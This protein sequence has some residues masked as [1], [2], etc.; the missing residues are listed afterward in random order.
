MRPSRCGVMAGRSGGGMVFEGEGMARGYREL[1]FGGWSLTGW[2][3]A[4]D[5]HG[6]I[7]RRGARVRGREVFG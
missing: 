2:G 3:G 4:C 1:V 7:R 5:N 6:E